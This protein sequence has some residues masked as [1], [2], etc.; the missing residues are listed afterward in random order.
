MTS[1]RWLTNSRPSQ[2]KSSNGLFFLNNIYGPDRRGLQFGD[3][4]VRIQRGGQGS[5]G[6][7]VDIFKGA[8]CTSQQTFY[9][10]LEADFQ[11]TLYR[12]RR[13]ARRLGEPEGQ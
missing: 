9:Q 12:F 6:S 11:M 13:R 8:T 1:E 3:E 2:P 10:G 7:K 4:G 5:M